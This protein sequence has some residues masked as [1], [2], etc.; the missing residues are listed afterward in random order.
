M[1]SPPNLGRQ[2]LKWLNEAFNEV[3]LR[4]VLYLT[5][6]ECEKGKAGNALIICNLQVHNE[7]A[8]PLSWPTQAFFFPLTKAAEA[9][10]GGTLAT[11]AFMHCLP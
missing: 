6:D 3:G 9:V 7:A 10:Q 5:N 11:A 4:K 8:L 2:G 1:T